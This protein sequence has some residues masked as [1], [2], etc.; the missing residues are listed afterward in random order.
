MSHPA[1]SW[2]K[3]FLYEVFDLVAYI[4][5]VAGI[6]FFV[7]FFIINPFNVVGS[8]M[9]PTIHE[10][11]F[12]LVDKITPRFNGYARGDIIVF[13]PPGKDVAYVKRVIG[14]PGETITI[15]N[16]VVTACKTIPEG[17]TNTPTSCQILD[18]SFLPPETQTA[19]TCGK[20]TFIVDSWYFV[21]GDN[22]WA[23]TDSRCCFWLY[24]YEKTNYLAPIDHIIGK[25]LVRVFP[26]PWW[27][28][29]P[30]DNINALTQ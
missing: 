25:V 10:K 12:I 15:K 26:S 20:D 28:T 19:T 1:M 27:F 3:L 4:V 9:Y 6:V 22:R 17:V 14:L 2:L 8:S 13:V 29:N 16:N 5:F 23:S 18:Q 24:C 11:D 21:M 7:R 30:Y